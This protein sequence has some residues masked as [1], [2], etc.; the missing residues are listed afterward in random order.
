MNLIDRVL[1]RRCTVC[2]SRLRKGIEGSEKSRDVGG[3]P[4]PFVLQQSRLTIYVPPFW[5]CREHSSTKVESE[6]RIKRLTLRA[7]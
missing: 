1:F 4:C 5:R 6:T 3:L 7:S 2:L